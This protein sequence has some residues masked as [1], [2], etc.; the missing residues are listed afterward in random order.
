MSKAM[1]LKA[2]AKNKAQEYHIPAQA[3]LQSYF[4]ERFLE[5]ISISSYKD[6]FVL[7]GGMLIASMVGIGSRTTMDMDTTLRNFPFSEDVLVDILSKICSIQ[8]DDDITFT[9]EYIKPIRED[10]VHGGFRAGF[11]AQFETITTPLKVD[12]TTGDRITPN[13]ILHQFRSVFDEESI[14]VWAYNLETILAEKVETILR[15]GIFNTRPR[16]FYDV[17]I[18]LKTFPDAFSSKIFSDAFQAT[19][20][21]RNSLNTLRDIDNILANIQNDKEMQQRWEQYCKDN[22]FAKEISFEAVLQVILK[23]SSDLQLD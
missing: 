14:D 20:E 12:I 6:A 8:L 11:I 17:Y 19:S 15:R 5:R 3:V 1:Q 9:L 10:D 2:R 22:D 18:L 13:A 4:L 23:I 21:H 16:D 7:K